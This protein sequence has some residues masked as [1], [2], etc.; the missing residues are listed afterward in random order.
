MFC[1]QGAGTKDKTL[2]RIM[3]SRSEV[4]LLDIRKEY[5]RMYGKSLYTDITVS[6]FLECY[7][8]GF[9]SCR[10]AWE[11]PLVDCSEPHRKGAVGSL[12]SSLIITFPTFLQ[13]WL[14]VLRNTTYINFSSLIGS[15]LVACADELQLIAKFLFAMKINLLPEKNISTLFHPWKKGPGDMSGN[16]SITQILVLTRRGLEMTLSYWLS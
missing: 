6:L 14:K 9:E 12:Q 8:W 5:K 15:L 11:L 3:V 2:I 7:W 10:N 4:D 16:L 1:V 13:P